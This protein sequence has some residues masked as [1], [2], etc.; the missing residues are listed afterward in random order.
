MILMYIFFAQNQKIRKSSDRELASR[1]KD[2]VDVPKWVLNNKINGFFN[3][4]LA[5]LSRVTKM[6]I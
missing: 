1:F 6:T 2:E 3:N 4:F 5:C